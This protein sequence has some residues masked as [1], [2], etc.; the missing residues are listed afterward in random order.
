MK[1]IQ[2]IDGAENCVYDIFSATDE[3]FA[4]IFPMG[5][6][7]AFIDEVYVREDAKLLDAAFANIWKRRIKKLM[8]WA[9]TASSSMNL[10]RRRCITQQEEMKKHVIPVDS[11]YGSTRQAH[12]LREC[13]H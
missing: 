4:L 8:L 3:E 13:M 7:I 9:S 2:I 10:K 6:D 1:N 11:I 12:F 5:T